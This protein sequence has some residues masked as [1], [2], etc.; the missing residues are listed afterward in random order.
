MAIYS[1][2]YCCFISA[3]NTE[4]KSIFVRCISNWWKI[5]VSYSVK[6]QALTLR[7]CLVNLFPIASCETIQCVNWSY[8]W[9]IHVWR[10]HCFTEQSISAPAAEMSLLCAFKSNTEAVL[11]RFL[12]T[13]WLE[14][15]KVSVCCTCKIAERWKCIS[16]HFNTWT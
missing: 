6:K 13:C 5:S 10:S 7:S 15:N 4:K 2:R 11:C 12:C 9:F 8:S 14:C 3:G 1:L 16:R